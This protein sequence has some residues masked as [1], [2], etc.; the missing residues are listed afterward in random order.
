MTNDTTGSKNVAA[1]GEAPGSAAYYG[2][3]S[4]SLQNPIGDPPGSAAY[5]GSVSDPNSVRLMPIGAGSQPIALAAG[6]LL[7]S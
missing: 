3:S 1:I 5:H 2:L 6:L 7:S 4:G